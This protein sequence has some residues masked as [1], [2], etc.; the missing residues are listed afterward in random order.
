MPFET[1]VA[2]VSLLKEYGVTLVD[3]DQSPLKVCPVPGGGA[4]FR[5]YALPQSA[6]DTDAFVS[7]SK[8]K[9]LAIDGLIGQSGCEWG[10]A[11]C[12][13]DTLVAGDQMITRTSCPTE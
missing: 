8:M 9:S 13:A 2:H 10:G 1:N 4:M 3:G 6:V 12:I 11:G 5:Q 7:V